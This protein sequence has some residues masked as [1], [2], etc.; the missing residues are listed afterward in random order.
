MTADSVTEIIRRLDALGGKVDV[1]ATDVAEIKPEVK[2]TNG[3]VTAIELWIARFEGGR[4]ALGWVTP[5]AI[6]VTCSVVGVVA[7][8]LIGG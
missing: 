3:R 2:K 1:I 8:R 7:A 6:G 4:A 5:V